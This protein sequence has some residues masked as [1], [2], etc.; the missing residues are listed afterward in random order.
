MDAMPAVLNQL[1]SINLE[2]TMKT[3]TWILGL[4][5]M[6]PLFLATSTAAQAQ[7]PVGRVGVGVTISDPGEALV[8][9]RTGSGQTSGLISGIL[10]PIQVASQFRLEPEIGFNRDAS[11]N[12]SGPDPTTKSTRIGLGGFWLWPTEHFTLSYGARAGYLRSITTTDTSR[13]D[14]PGYFIAPAAGG[15]YFLSDYLSFGAEM[16][17]KFS[18]WT[19]R[20]SGS[21]RKETSFAT[22]GVLV[23][24]FYFP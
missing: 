14:A 17:L 6:A 13:I 15:E 23:L 24:R 4:F 21:N 18:S 16:Q 1:D 8:T 19:W 10:V 9:T 12:S 3:S 2:M 5:A 7:P 20:D 11:T 22:V